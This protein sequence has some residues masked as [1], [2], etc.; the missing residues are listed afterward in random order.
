MMLARLWLLFSILFI[1]QTAQA[2]LFD[3]REQQAAKLF[4]KGE[5]K[6]AAAEFTDD[7]RRGVAQYRAGQYSQAAD[8]FEAV[9]RDSPL[10]F[11]QHV[12]SILQTQ[13]N[14]NITI[15]GPIPAPMEKRAG[16]FRAQLILMAKQ[17]SSLQNLLRQHIMQIENLKPGRKVRWSIDVDPI[18]LF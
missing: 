12:A 8:S 18:E 17:R 5:F 3:N 16:R 1:A 10:D 2:G 14:T 4:E 9:D 13:A 6:K 11:L 15:F 7:Y